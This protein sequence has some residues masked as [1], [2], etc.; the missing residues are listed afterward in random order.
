[1][2]LRFRKEKK[3]GEE[4]SQLIQQT[5]DATGAGTDTTAIHD[6]EDGEIDAI[7][8]KA[9]PLNADLMIIEDSAVSFAKKKCTLTQMLGAL[10]P[11]HVIGG[12]AYSAAW[13]G[14]D[15]AA[16]RNALYDK[17]ESLPELIWRTPEETAAYDF[18]KG[19]LTDN[20]NWNDMDLTGIVPAGTTIA[21]IFFV[22]VDNAANSYMQL[23]KN[24]QTA[25]YQT[26]TLR[27]MVANVPNDNTLLVGLD[28]NLKCEVIF[29]PKPSSWSVINV[30]VLGWY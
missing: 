18:V 23:R 9:T 14:D 17:I 3:L 13:N 20:T 10:A 30:I 12:E 2:S 22:I 6:D 19:T 24:G 11:V 28:G 29:V 26:H 7:A 27:T 5:L 4:N 21:Y 8:S 1:M 25:V 16:T 15:F